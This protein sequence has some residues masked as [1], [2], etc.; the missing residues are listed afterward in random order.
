MTE[1]GRAAISPRARSNHRKKASGLYEFYLATREHD[2]LYSIKREVVRLY[3][4]RLIEHAPREHLYM[5]NLLR[6]EF[7]LFEQVQSDHVVRAEIVG[8]GIN[9]YLALQRTGD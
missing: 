5:L 3:D 4:E 9:I 8:Q 6:H 1:S 7:F 2:H